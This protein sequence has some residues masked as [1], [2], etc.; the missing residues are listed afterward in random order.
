MYEVQIDLKQQDLGVVL[1]ALRQRADLPVDFILYA[2]TGT[3]L[4][5]FI[6]GIG[7]ISETAHVKPGGSFFQVRGDFPVDSAL[8]ANLKPGYTGKAKID[9][10]RRP[11]AAVMLRKFFDYWRVEWML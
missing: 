5:T 7:S 6:H 1:R 9:L 4:R 3:R 10:G 2:H 11:L 8:A